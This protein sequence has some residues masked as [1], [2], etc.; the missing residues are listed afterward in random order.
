[1]KSLNDFYEETNNLKDSDFKEN[2]LYILDSIN[3]LINKT[4]NELKIQ[5]SSS[6]YIEYFENMKDKP[7]SSL[8]EALQKNIVL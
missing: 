7:V 4:I 2:Q 6:K 8:E 1:M 5:N 3:I